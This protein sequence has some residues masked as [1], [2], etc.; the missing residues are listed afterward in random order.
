MKKLLILLLI[1]TCSIMCVY[2]DEKA[3]TSQNQPN[4]RKESQIQGSN[5]DNLPDVKVNLRDETGVEI[6]AGIVVPVINM[7][8]VSTETCPVG[9]KVKF[10]AT[11]DL[12]VGDIKVIPEDT[13]F[14]GYIEKI[15]EP[16]VGTNAAMKVKITKFVFPDGHEQNIKAYIYTTNNNV[17]GGELTA[18]AEWVKMPHYQDTYQGISWIHRGATLQ[19]RP[20]GK[21]SM[22]AHTKLPV[23][24]RHL[25]I[26]VAPVNLTH[27]TEE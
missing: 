17:I 24:E 8:E 12:F 27:I 3:A 20:G 1:Y 9:Y 25:I 6:P 2:A 19:L 10:V 11:N 4:I 16:I 21:R 23:G 15:N 22:G 7:Q 26:F 5:Q 14:Y 18:P 13:A